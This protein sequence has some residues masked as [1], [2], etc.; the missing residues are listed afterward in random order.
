MCLRPELQLAEP[1]SQG[2][3]W[4]H[5]LQDAALAATILSEATMTRLSTC[6]Y[7]YISNKPFVKS[8]TI[9]VQ[10]GSTKRAGGSTGDLREQK[11]TLNEH[12]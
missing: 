8:F 6:I 1:I 11:E 5:S 3:G 9:S 10:I 4:A 12:K 2:P 7:I